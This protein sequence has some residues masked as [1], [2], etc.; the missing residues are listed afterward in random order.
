M[1]DIAAALWTVAIIAA[2]GNMSPGP[3]FVA[4]TY[5]SVVRGRAS[6]ALVALG[7]VF[8]NG[9]WAGA[10]LFGVAALFT[11]FPT[12]FV[13]IKTAGALYLCYLGYKLLRYARVPYDVAGGAT[14]SSPWSAFRS[15]LATTLSNPK[16]AI[17]YASALSTAA[18][19]SATWFE[20]SLML[21]VVIAVS[22]A[23]FATVVL[24]LSTQRAA[25][26][27]RRFKVYFESLFGALLLGFCLKQLFAK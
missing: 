18:P 10:A 1:T 19:A 20:L 17:Y 23:W 24:V 3:D 4:V 26:A 22:G 9:L 5:A 2:I 15:G 13:L 27:F 6:A 21:T 7:V 14:Q 16:A 12:M 8:G 11:L 25:N